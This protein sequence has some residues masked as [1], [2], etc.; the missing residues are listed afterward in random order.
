MISTYNLLR[1]QIMVAV[2]LRNSAALY[3]ARHICEQTQSHGSGASLLIE[4]RSNPKL[5]HSG[6]KDEDEAEEVYRKD[7]C[8]V[9]A[10]ATLGGVFRVGGSNVPHMVYGNSRQSFTANTLLAGTEEAYR[11]Y[12][13][14][15]VAAAP[16]AVYEPSRNAIRQPEIKAMA[17]LSVRP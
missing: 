4:I 14:N 7:D 10:I 12:D 6:P 16:K 17:M 15:R 9:L 2:R 3:L 13:R 8:D 5:Q 11:Q 1:G